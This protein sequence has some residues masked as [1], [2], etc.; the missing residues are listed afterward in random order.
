M[1]T[2]TLNSFLYGCDAPYSPTDAALNL[3]TPDYPPSYILAALADTLIPVEH[4]FMLYDKLQE[5]GVESYI[6]KVEGAAHGFAERPASDWPQGMD[7]WK[8]AIK[9]SVDW[10]I[11]KVQ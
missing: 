6:T 9:D 3:I 8:D 1:A 4:S 10:A 2:Q 7:Y 5:H 11:A